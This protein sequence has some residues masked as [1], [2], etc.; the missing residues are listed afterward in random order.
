MKTLRMTIHSCRFN[1]MY[2]RFATV[3]LV[4]SFLLL[5][6]DENA[7]DDNKN[8]TRFFS[9]DDLFGGV[10]GGG[11]QVCIS[12]P[13]FGGSTP[14]EC[15]LNPQQLSQRYCKGLGQCTASYATVCSSGR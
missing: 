13:G 15:G 1:S 5:G 14:G 4:L 11:C 12:R 2:S 7:E 3:A 8:S 6:C 10:N 9:W